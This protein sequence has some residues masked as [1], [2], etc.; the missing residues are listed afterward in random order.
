M[1]Q[2]WLWSVQNRNTTYCTF[3]TSEVTHEL[4]GKSWSQSVHTDK[5][6]RRNKDVKNIYT[7]MKEKWEIIQLYKIKGK[8]K[9]HTSIVHFT[10]RVTCSVAE[11][12]D[13]MI[14]HRDWPYVSAALSKGFRWPLIWEHN[15]LQVQ[16]SAVMHVSCWGRGTVWEV[17]P[18]LQQQQGTVAS[19]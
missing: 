5:T 2:W 15:W 8:N 18:R 12:K 10:D 9:K 16:P 3:D 19:V 17:K 14:Y 7:Q 1:S 11:Y 13:F 6:M 4:W